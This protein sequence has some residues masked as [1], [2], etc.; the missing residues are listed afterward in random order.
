MLLLICIV[1]HYDAYNHPTSNNWV[2]FIHG[3]GGSSAIW[4]KQLRE[5]RKSHNVLLIDLRGHGKSKGG[6]IA[7]LKRYS[8]ARIGD[9]VMEVL[10]HL[11]IH[12][13]HFVGISLGSVI[14]RELADRYPTRMQ[15][16]ILGGAIMELNLRGR[17]LMKLGV[18]FKSVVPYLILYK[19][20]AFIIMPRKT[21]RESRSLFVREAKKLYQK[22]F[23]RWFQLASQV[24]PLLSLLRMSL[25]KAPI[26]FIMGSE[27]HMFLPA[28][29]K[30]VQ[31]QT[32]AQLHVIPDCGHVVNVEQPAVFNEVGLSFIRKHSSLLAN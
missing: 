25:P 17:V 26:L 3:A 21:H 31:T 7:Q 28:V 27:D 2:T 1:L 20:F 23:K 12:K 15:S 32:G 19:L 30:L 11:K 8:F 22:E 4:Y 5:F 14:I 9:E 24:N 13:S 29:K 18:W 6:P 10:D 16:L